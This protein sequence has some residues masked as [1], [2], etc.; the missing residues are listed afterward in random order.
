MSNTGAWHVRG[1]VLTG[2]AVESAGRPPAVSGQEGSQMDTVTVRLSA[3]LVQ[4]WEAAYSEY[5]TADRLQASEP[6]PMKMA[7]L[8]WAVAS[9]WRDL[10]AT[11]GLPWCLV[12]SLT[13]SAEA[14]EGQSRRDRSRV[15]PAR[16]T[17]PK[18][19]PGSG[20]RPLHP[21]ATWYRSLDSQEPGTGGGGQ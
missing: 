10:G 6:N 17:E 19:G 13:T 21:G 16:P 18:S 7:R 2:S 15:V 1:E 3:E 20:P 11:P 5:V 9:A 8:E 4:R 14:M 12:A